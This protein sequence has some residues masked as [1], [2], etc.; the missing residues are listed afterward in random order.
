LLLSGILLSCLLA[1]G[2]LSL[3]A[4]TRRAAP[5]DDA[6][7]SENGS[8]SP[9]EIAAAAEPDADEQ[10]RQR[11]EAFARASHELRTPL[12]AIIGYSELIQRTDNGT[13]DP[14]RRMDYVRNIEM[15]GRHMLDVVTGVLDF[16][17]L[18]AGA[19]TLSLTEL[20]LGDTC[21]AA[22]RLVNHE[23]GEKGV[24]L[25]CEVPPD[26]PMIQADKRAI[27]QMLLNLLGNAV[28]FSSEGD[29]VTVR[30]WQ[31]DQMVRIAVSDTG[32]GIPEDEI[33]AIKQS[34][35]RA[36]NT[37]GTTIG[38]G[39]GLAVTANLVELHGGSLTAAN[40]IGGGAE[41]IITLPIRQQNAAPA[42]E[43]IQA[44]A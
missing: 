6:I 16:S 14:S 17:Q 30:A 37:R 1:V 24:A 4:R 8:V 2:V 31:D 29:A 13:A 25:W 5:H 27:M 7:T 40:A 11:T 22:L 20:E 36:S 33:S 43:P 15:A 32:P 34:F 42:E 38:H 28:K 44:V 26:L 10:I 41:F 35:R 21:S 12:N 9:V 23:A 18:E 39:L 3:S 19:Y